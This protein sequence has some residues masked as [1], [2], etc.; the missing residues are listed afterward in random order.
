[1]REFAKWVVVALVTAILLMFTTQTAAA[2]EIVQPSADSAK[3]TIA[4]DQVINDDL[5]AFGGVVN[6]VGTVNGD[7]IAMGGTVNI[8]GSV[9]GDV[10]VTGGNV[11]VSGT[12]GDDL[13]VMGGTVTVTG[14][15]TDDVMTCGGTISFSEKSTI[16]GDFL[17]AGG[18]IDLGSKVAGKAIINAGSVVV[19]GSVALTSEINAGTI[20]ITKTAKLS[21]LTYSSQRD[22]IEQSGAVI[23]EKD[24]KPWQGVDP[25]AGMAAMVVGL[26]VA[27]LLAVATWVL[28]AVIIILVFRKMLKETAEVVEKKF[29]MSVGVG[30]MML[31]VVPVA[32][33]LAMFTIIGIPIAVMALLLWG[34]A[35]YVSGIVASFI[36]GRW[37][38]KMTVKKEPNVWLSFLVGI[39]LYQIIVNIPV[40]GPVAFILALVVGLGAP[41]MLCIGRK[42]TKKK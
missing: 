15:I 19:S 12:V 31:L 29:W 9:T 3:V 7:V 33:L 1:M 24:R 36:F 41:V 35:V 11:M 22:L 13:R 25:K 18:M 30:F 26:M 20:S 6:V 2:A 38:L 10:N 27:K 23:A 4:K 16:G 32:A 34:M 39:V 14:N 21:K 17:A 5:V 28:F 40:I 8:E 37:L 42:Q